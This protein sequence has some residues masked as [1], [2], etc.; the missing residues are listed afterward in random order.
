MAQLLDGFRFPITLPEF[1]QTI[2]TNSECRRGFFE[3]IMVPMVVPSASGGVPGTG[4][5]VYGVPPGYVAI[6]DSD[7]IASADA[8]GDSL[9][10]TVIVDQGQAD[11]M[12]AAV[13]IPVT[14]SITIPQTA[15]GGVPVKSNLALIV[16]NQSSATVKMTFQGCLFLAEKA[17]H[18][19]YIAPFFKEQNR[20]LQDIITSRR[21]FRAEAKS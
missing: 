13:Q 18:S 2:A 11:A 6:A 7:C 17:F 16:E 8:Y 21:A 15:I 19:E 14:E 3:L 12:I 9:Y 5:F 1:L 10:L 4:E 20:G